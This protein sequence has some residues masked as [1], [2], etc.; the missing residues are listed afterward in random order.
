MKKCSQCGTYTIAETQCPK[1]GGQAVNAHPARFSIED[2]YGEYR[3][4]MKRELLSKQNTETED[5]VT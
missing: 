5:K 1:C 3:R 4:T 2:R